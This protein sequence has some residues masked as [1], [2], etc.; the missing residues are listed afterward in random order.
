VDTRF[1]PQ[2]E[3]KRGSWEERLKEIDREARAA[4]ARE[5]GKEPAELRWALLVE[6]GEG[7]GPLVARVKPL[8]GEDVL[9]LLGKEAPVKVGAHLARLLE[10]HAEEPLVGVAVIGIGD[11][12]DAR[13]AG[14]KLGDLARRPWVF[15]HPGPKCD[16]PATIGEKVERFLQVIDGIAFMEG[17]KA[18]RR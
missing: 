13:A 11:R 9:T 4:L 14:W 8:L 7:S 6:P 16:L 18:S 17:P 12:E 3:I 10:A 5:T 15:A 1:G 2:V